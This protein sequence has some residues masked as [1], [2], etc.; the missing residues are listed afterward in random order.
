MYFDVS[1]TSS[2]GLIFIIGIFGDKFLLKKQFVNSLFSPNVLHFIRRLLF[3]G[4]LVLLMCLFSFG[5]FS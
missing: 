4:R 1:P 3:I 2:T 5:A